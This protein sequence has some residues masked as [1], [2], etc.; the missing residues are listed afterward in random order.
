MTTNYDDMN[1]GTLAKLAKE[2]GVFPG[3]GSGARGK[4]IKKDLLSALKIGAEA[5]V[6]RLTSQQKYKF[7]TQYVVVKEIP[8]HPIG[9]VVI[10]LPRALGIAHVEAG[11]I[12]EIPGAF[13][14]SNPMAMNQPP[15]RYIRTKGDKKN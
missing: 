14:G 6:E 1:V 4:V 8:G 9:A 5:V 7:D 3:E 2:L 13:K 12:E 15:T 11:A 10:N